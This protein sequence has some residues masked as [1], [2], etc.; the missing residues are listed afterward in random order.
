MKLAEA[1]GLQGFRVNNV[2]ELEAA[3]QAALEAQEK[4]QGTVIDCNIFEG[5]LVRPMVNG[6]KHITEFLV[7]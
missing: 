7:N 5:E 3:I 2:E 6:G 4:G 1:N